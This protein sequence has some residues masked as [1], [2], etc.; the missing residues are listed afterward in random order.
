MLLLAE[1]QLALGDR[2]GA[3]DLIENA[4]LIAPAFSAAARLERQLVPAGPD[5]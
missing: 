5:N 1:R 2:R 4:L 3:R